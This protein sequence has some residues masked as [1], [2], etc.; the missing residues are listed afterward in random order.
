MSVLGFYDLGGNAGEWMWDELDE[1]TGKRV[2]RGGHWC[3]AA[4]YCPVA[5]RNYVNPDSRYDNLGFRVAL[6]SVP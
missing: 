1:K 6:S 5:F 4:G 2:L 3:H